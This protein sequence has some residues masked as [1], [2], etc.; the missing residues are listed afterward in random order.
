MVTMSI[1][2]RPCAV[3]HRLHS[4]PAPPNRC[5]A[6]QLCAPRLYAPVAYAHLPAPQLYT[7]RCDTPVA[8]AHRPADGYPGPSHPPPP[9]TLPA[10]LPPRPAQRVAVLECALKRRHAVREMPR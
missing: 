1:T 10:P 7:T 6:P 2:S 9:C 4:M 3:L 5:P 8:F